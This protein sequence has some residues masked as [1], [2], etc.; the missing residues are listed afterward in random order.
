MAKWNAIPFYVGQKQ[1]Q[2]QQQQQQKDDTAAKW[3]AVPFYAAPPRC[4]R[5]VGVSVF[6]TSINIMSV[7]NAV[8]ARISAAAADGEKARTAR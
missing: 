6:G 1:Q 5:L 7:A 3:N 4:A 8:V 2:Q